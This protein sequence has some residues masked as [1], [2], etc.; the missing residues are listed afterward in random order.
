MGAVYRAVDTRLDREVAIKVLPRE[1]ATD[2]E[3]LARLEREAKALA[4][5]DHP[6]IVGIY[7]LETARG[8]DGGAR[9]F[10]V[11]E[12]VEGRT[13]DEEIPEAG[14][15]LERFFELATPIVGTVGAAH[16]RGL[17]HRDLKPANI[18]VAA[19]GEIKILDFGLAKW[20]TRTGAEGDLDEE[21][22]TRTLHGLTAENQIVGT[23]A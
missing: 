9:T 18:M 17:V 20:A 19:S 13:L 1:L 12:L 15:P 11:M 3:R 23:G 14:M 7:S 5:L 2:P 21:A 4:A 10:L 22:P 6:G 8:P 16:D